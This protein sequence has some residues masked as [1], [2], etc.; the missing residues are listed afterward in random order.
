MSR[1]ILIVIALIGL[2]GLS[3]VF[4]SFYTINEGERGIILTNGSLSGV[5]DPG[6]NFKLPFVQSIVPIS[7]RNHVYRYEG[8][9]SYS[10]DQQIAGITLSVN[11][12]VPKENVQKIY[13]EYGD[14]DQAVERAVNPRVFENLKNVFGQ[15]TAQRAIQERGNLNSDIFVAIQKSVMNSGLNVTS[16]QIENI[17]YSDTYESA[18]EAAAKAKADIETA[19]SRL[20]QVNQEAQQ[21]VAQASAEA[22]AKKL[23]ADADAYATEAAGKATA[24]AIRER[25]AALRDNPDLV[26]LVAAE[27]WDGKLPVQ[28]VPG[29]AVPFID[30]SHK[31]PA[32]AK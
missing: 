26:S 6:L 24:N 32:E 5:A 27:K 19:K 31:V 25:G 7:V 1:F 3:A 2:I 22:Q 28:M 11:V 4:G 9:Q 21:K 15:Y 29:S 8:I 23:Q 18:V 10:Y 30:L 16:V 12:E 17:D 14:L 13:R 20:A